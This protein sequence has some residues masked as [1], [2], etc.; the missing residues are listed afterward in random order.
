L[1]DVPENNPPATARA[2]DAA[3]GGGIGILLCWVVSLFGYEL[4]PAAAATLTTF[5]IIAAAALGK[6][7]IRGL[8]MQLWRGA[9]G[10]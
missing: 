5:I 4:P 3:S 7:G 9:N 6:R 10:N 8:A 2:F 1:T